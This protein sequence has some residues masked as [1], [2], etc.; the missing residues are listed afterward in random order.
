MESPAVILLGGIL[1]VAFISVVAKTIILPLLGIDWP[2]RPV[3]APW[4]FSLLSVTVLVAL[5]AAVLG[6]LRDSPNAAL[7]GLAIVLVTWL[8]VV[9]YVAFRRAL[10]DRSH[11]E[12]ATMLQARKDDETL[13]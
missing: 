13:E 5:A 10:A 2:F 1:L 4:R 3:R 8:T 12:L 7:F 11:R 9:R 6:L